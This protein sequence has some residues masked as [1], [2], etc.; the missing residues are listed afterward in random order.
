MPVPNTSVEH[1]PRRRRPGA[2]RTGAARTRAAPPLSSRGGDPR[3]RSATHRSPTGSGLNGLASTLCR[4]A[5]RRRSASMTATTAAKI[6][7]EASP[8]ASRTQL[9]APDQHRSR[10]ALPPRGCA[11]HE[12]QQEAHVSRHQ[13][14]RYDIRELA[15]GAERPQPTPSARQPSASCSETRRGRHFE[16]PSSGSRRARRSSGRRGRLLETPGA[17]ALE[18]HQGGD[19]ARWSDCIMRAAPEH[20]ASRAAH[21]LRTPVSAGDAARKAKI[22]QK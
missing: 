16:A 18:R 7:N 2:G 11:E 21:R 20:G 22:K 5:T 10:T 12:P 8:A 4:A 1:E 13:D 17:A 15:V 9:R 3:S 6:T 14:R 19:P